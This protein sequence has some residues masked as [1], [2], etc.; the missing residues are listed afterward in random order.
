MGNRRGKWRT[1]TSI[2]V[3]PSSSMVLRIWLS[4]VTSTSPVSSTILDTDTTSIEY[5]YV[6]SLPLS[7]LPF[8]L[9]LVL[10]PTSDIF[11]TF[12]GCCESLQEIPYLHTWDHWSV[13]RKEK[14]R[15]GPPYFCYCRWSLP[16]HA[17]WS[18]KPVYFN[19]VC[20]SLIH[21][22]FWKHCYSLK[23]TVENLELERQ[24]TQRRLFNILLPLQ[25]ELEVEHSSN[26]FSKL[27][28][29]WRLSVTPRPQGTTTPPVLYVS[30]HLLHCLL[31][32]LTSLTG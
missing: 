22:I 10:T 25:E 3:T 27:T 18:S 32:I 21:V 19:Y 4:S 24:R 12:L 1:L 9:I 29:S 14:E 6:S 8:H 2:P 16:C 30:I 20:Y 23:P 15:V 11:R 5:T 26:K 31:H 17:Q 28:L 7:C 13:Q